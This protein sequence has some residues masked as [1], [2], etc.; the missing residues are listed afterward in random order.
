[1]FGFRPTLHPQM[2]R[3]GLNDWPLETIRENTKTCIVYIYT[4]IYTHIYIYI[5]LCVCLAT[6]HA[7]SHLPM[8]AHNPPP[9]SQVPTINRVCE[10]RPVCHLLELHSGFTCWCPVE[11]TR[12]WAMNLRIPSKEAKSMRVY[13]DPLLRTCKFRKRLMG[14][15][16]GDS[17][18]RAPA[19]THLRSPC[20]QMRREDATSMDT[21]R[22]EVPL[23][24]LI[25]RL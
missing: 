20:P 25:S 15:P 13:R 9:C 19:R 23:E 16:L 1:M 7:R 8:Y 17:G 6:S 18:L 12:V 3:N 22:F 24:V 10:S 21:P 14:T 5:Y 4:Y 2:L 11:M